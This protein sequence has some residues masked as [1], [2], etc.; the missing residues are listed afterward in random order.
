MPRA[1]DVL[2]VRRRHWLQALSVLALAPWAA[3]GQ[4][5]GRPLRV[6]ASF[7]ILGDL[8]RQFGLQR[9]APVL[10]QFAQS[11]GCGDDQQLVE[12]AGAGLM[13]QQRGH[14]GGEAIF[15]PRAVVGIGRAR[16]MPAGSHGGPV[17]RRRRQGRQLGLMVPGVLE[18]QQLFAVDDGHHGALGKYHRVHPSQFTRSLSG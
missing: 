18:Q 10:A 1:S 15:R 6:V 13:V 3:G 2:L 5:Q 8:A 17:D 14:A 16:L 9:L 12:V 7:S 11:P 4:A